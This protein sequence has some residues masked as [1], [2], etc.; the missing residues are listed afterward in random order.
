MKNIFL[1][2]VL[3]TTFIACEKDQ[4]KNLQPV[5]QSIDSWVRE[6]YT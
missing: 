6:S 4:A 2:L 1:I 5:L 3:S